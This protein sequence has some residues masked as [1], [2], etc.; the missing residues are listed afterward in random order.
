MPFSVKTKC[1]NC[2]KDFMLGDIIADLLWFSFCFDCIDNS[3][4]K[5]LLDVLEET[6]EENPNYHRSVEK[7]KEK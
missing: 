5:D 3:E 4:R 1:M 7:K 6:K 2:K